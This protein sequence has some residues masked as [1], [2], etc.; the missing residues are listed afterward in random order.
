ME[1]KAEKK[2][3]AIS[4][5]EEERLKYFMSLSMKE[6]LRHLE[7]LNAFFD[8]MMPAKNKKIAQQLRDMGF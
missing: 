7:E 5:E 3:P 8:K 4:P 2:S 6:K 1:K